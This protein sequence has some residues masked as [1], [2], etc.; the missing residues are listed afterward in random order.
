MC[1]AWGG[2]TVCMVVAP[3]VPYSRHTA[4]GIGR[5]RGVLPLP[6]H[7][8]GHLPCGSANP[9]ASGHPACPARRWWWAHRD[10]LTHATGVHVSLLL[11]PWAASDKMD[12]QG[13]G[14]GFQAT[15]W[16]IRKGQP[17]LEEHWKRPHPSH[18]KLSSMKCFRSVLPVSNYI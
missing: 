4:E 1:Y 9:D 6:P 10:L 17:L 16:L 15:D 8:E 2:N 14:T 5:L 18:H 7:A 3:C 11:N 12:R 13:G